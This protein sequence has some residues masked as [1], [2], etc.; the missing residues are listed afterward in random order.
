MI[1]LDL[2][3]TILNRTILIHNYYGFLLRV[4]WNSTQK[5]YESLNLDSVFWLTV[6]K[7][8]K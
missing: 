4:Y 6:G 8:C 5:S 7:I 2:L 3:L 1:R